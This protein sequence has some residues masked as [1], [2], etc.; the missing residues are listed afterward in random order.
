MLSRLCNKH[1]RSFEHQAASQH[2]P[3]ALYISNSRGISL[4]QC[5]VYH[6]V[7]SDG[8]PILNPCWPKVLL[9]LYGQILVYVDL[10]LYWLLYACVATATVFSLS[11]AAAPQLCKAYALHAHV[12]IHCIWGLDLC[13]V[14]E[15]VCE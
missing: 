6:S 9:V 7:D 11:Q 1:H 3:D 4:N 15:L 10:Q 12:R 13:P 8:S 5:C 14:V 2:V